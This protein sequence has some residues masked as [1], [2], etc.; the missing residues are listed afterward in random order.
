MVIEAS[1]KYMIEHS[2]LLPDGSDVAA[3]YMDDLI[4]RGV[5]D[6]DKIIDPKTKQK[7]TGCV[8]VNYSDSFNQYEYNYRDDCSIT[9][10][11][12]PE[13][14]NIETESKSV[15]IGK[16]YGEL[17]EPTR[18]GYNF[19]GWRGKNMFDEETIL[20][21]ISGAVHENG[22][23]V[24]NPYRAH[25]LY[26]STIGGI[27]KDILSFKPNV[28]YTLSY[29][30]YTE[31][32]P[33]LDKSTFLFISFNYSDETQLSTSLK[34][35]TETFVTGTSSE[36][37][38]IDNIAISYGNSGANVHVRYI[39]VEEGNTATEYEPYQLFDNDTVVTKGSDYTLHAIWEVAS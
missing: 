31:Y 26:S 37:K 29:I 16:T 21:A 38:S 6:N 22:Y 27:S 39:Q 15:L 36:S 35:Q 30:G 23:Y 25:Q 34:K 2:E 9:I 17:P 12:D 20:M 13:G 5:I 4:N 7:L 19:V 14:G 18:T 11:F 33:E 1:K 24:F 28:K 8:V 10:S 32:V 3:I